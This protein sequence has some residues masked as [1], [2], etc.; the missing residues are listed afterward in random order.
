MAKKITK[1]PES[2][3]VD[4]ETYQLYTAIKLKKIA[5]ETKKDLKDHVQKI[6]M[7]TYERQGETIY[8]IYTIRN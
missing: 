1:L 6:H 5:D 2:V 4:G 3:Q 7:E 8:A